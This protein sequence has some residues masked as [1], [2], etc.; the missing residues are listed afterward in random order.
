MPCWRVSV[1]GGDA[2]WAKKVVVLATIFA[3]EAYPWSGKYPSILPSLMY[4]RYISIS[5]HDLEINFLTS[6]AHL[7]SHSIYRQ[8]QLRLQGNRCVISTLVSP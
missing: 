1:V 6:S 4:T 7:C 5:H 2:W 8:A 3:G